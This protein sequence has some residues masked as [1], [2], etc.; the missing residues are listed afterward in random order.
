MENR[1][2]I[3]TLCLAAVAYACGP[4]RHSSGLAAPA[5]V[6]WQEAKSADAIATTFDV[7]PGENGV[8]FTLSVANNTKE[9]V[10]LRFASSQTHDFKVLNS[11]GETVWQ[12]SKDRMFTQA[13]QSK[14]VKPQDTL[15]IVNDWSIKN[16]KGEYVA[17][18]ILNTDT[19]PIERRTVFQIP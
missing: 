10:E 5:D 4:W 14:V 13:M 9:A 19:H 8:D 15:T 7:T 2:I 18:A 1:L 3:T 16:M 6:V 11:R 12:W 17:V